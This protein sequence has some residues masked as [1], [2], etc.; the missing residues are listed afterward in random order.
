MMLLGALGLGGG[1]ATVAVPGIAGAATLV[2]AATSGLS[3]ASILSGTASVLG[4]VSTIAAGAADADAAE[5]SA[6][7]AET[8][9]ENENLKGIERRRSL[10][11]AMAEAVGQADVAHAASGVDLSF[12]SAAQA[13]QAAFREGD[14]ALSGDV[15]TQQSRQNRLY[16]RARSYRRTAKRARIGG[17][18]GGLAQGASALS[19][20]S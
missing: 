1:A 19:R 12:G 8:E 2:P 7:D 9:A 15:Y 20:R 6:I 3:I 16:E 4:V 17:W 10:K 18:L 13:R 11:A 14:L 5:A